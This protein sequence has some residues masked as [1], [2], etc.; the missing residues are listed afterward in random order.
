MKKQLLGSHW[1]LTSSSKLYQ[2]YR[3]VE[4]VATR[5]EDRR[6]N[7]RVPSKPY[8]EELNDIAIELKVLDKK[9]SS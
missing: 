3:R 6:R 7:G 1:E 4:D 5:L 8:L 2:L 9:V